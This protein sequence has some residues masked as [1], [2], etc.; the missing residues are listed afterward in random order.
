MHYQ[1]ILLSELY[2]QSSN[3]GIGGIGGRL[4]GIGKNSDKK[5]QN[6]DARHFFSAAIRMR[7]VHQSAFFISDCNC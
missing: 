1:H 7:N 2:R 5:P 4:G 3:G 6:T